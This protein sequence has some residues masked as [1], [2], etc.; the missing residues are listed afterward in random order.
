MTADN[1]KDARI[2]LRKAQVDAATS[3]ESTEQGAPCLRSQSLWTATWPMRNSPRG[4]GQPS[5]SGSI[6]SDFA[7]GVEVSCWTR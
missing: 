4:W 6:W 2:E 7:K 5:L 3:K 1:V